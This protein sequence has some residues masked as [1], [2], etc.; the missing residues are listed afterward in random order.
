MLEE[1]I[2]GN[3][4]PEETAMLS[5]LLHELRMAYV[6]LQERQA[7]GGS[8]IHAR[9]GAKSQAGPWPTKAKPW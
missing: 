6:A 2:Q 3:R 5:H 1:K 9:P 4:T 7:D 8:S